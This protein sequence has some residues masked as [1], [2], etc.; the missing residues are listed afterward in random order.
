MP[1]FTPQA[2]SS[3]AGNVAAIAST[4]IVNVTEG[5]VLNQIALNVTTPPDGAPT[6]TLVITIDGGTPIS[7]NLYTAALTWAASIL[8]FAVIGDGG[9]ANDRLVL[10]LNTPYRSSLQ[11]AFN[12]TGASATVGTV[13]ASVLQSK[14]IRTIPNLEFLM[15]D[16][17]DHVTP[18]SGLAPA[19]QVSINGAAFITAANSPA[20]EVANGFYSISLTDADLAG[21][22]IGVK[23]TSSGADQQA[24]TLIMIP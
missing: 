1:A 12:V 10:T 16:S 22:V 2:I 4:N 13:Q 9:N 24:F 3:I 7:I 19:V 23:C 21:A 20:T 11:V 5:G 17:T 8:P 14:I 6:V 18:K 15:V